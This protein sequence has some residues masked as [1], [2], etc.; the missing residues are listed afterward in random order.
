MAEEAE[1]ET[2]KAA[3]HLRNGA[4]TATKNAV[5]GS[6]VK[7]DKHL[8]RQL[9]QPAPKQVLVFSTLLP[10]MAFFIAV[11]AQFCR[12]FVTCRIQH[13]HPQPPTP[14]TPAPP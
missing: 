5:A 4:K 12:Y 13:P 1:E 10:A 8:L 3:K 7:K 9:K 2:A 11:V 14:H 6:R